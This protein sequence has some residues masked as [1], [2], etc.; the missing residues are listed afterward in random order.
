MINLDIVFWITISILCKLA[1][2][3]IPLYLETYHLLL[4]TFE[5]N[6]FVADLVNR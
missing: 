5:P 2:K 1:A 3:A 4:G 6:Q